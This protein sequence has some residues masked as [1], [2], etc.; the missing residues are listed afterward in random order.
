MTS[1]IHTIKRLPKAARLLWADVLSSALRA[2]V[3]NPDA[4]HLWLLLHALPKLCLRLPP[5]GGK[6]KA[7]S[8]ASKPFIVDLLKKAKE[9]DWSSLFEEAVASAR[10][11]VAKNGKKSQAPQQ[12][13]VKDWVTTLP[14]SQQA[15]IKDRVTSLIEEGLLSKA[16]AALDPSGMHILSPSVIATLEKKHPKGNYLPPALPPPDG[17]ERPVPLS[18]EVEA[19]LRALR[20]FHKSTAP[21][22]SR[23]R[24]S[25]LLDA[26]DIPT[27]DADG[28]VSK[29]LTKL[30][31]L[32]VAGDAPTSIAQWIAGAPLHPLMKKDGGVRPIAVGEV[33]RRLVSRACCAALNTSE[34]FLELGQVGV[35]VKGGAEAA[36]QAVRLAITPSAGV[37]SL[38]VLKV[39][40]EN[41]F[42][43]ADRLAIL[44]ELEFNFPQLVPWFRF[45]Y[46][47]PACLMCQGE[48]LPFGSSQGVQQGD[49]LGPFFFAL[50]LRPCCLKLKD[51]L[52]DSL[53]VWYL[54]DGTIVG[55]KEEV[56]K[57]WDVIHEEA[58]KVALRVNAGKC[59]L[60]ATADG[61]DLID[62]PSS[63]IRCSSQGFDLLGSPIGT[64]E[65]CNSYIK[66]KRVDKIAK[67]L[68]N[69]CL[70]NDPQLELTLLRSC[71]A[72][73][74]FAFALRSAPAPDIDD[75]AAA[76]DSLIDATWDER[77]GL[78][79]SP[80][81]KQQL[82]LPIR[83]GG[84][85][86]TTAADT[87]NAAFLGNIIATAP[88]VNVLLGRVVA[89]DEFSGAEQSL[90]ALKSQ[91]GSNDPLPQSVVGFPAYLSPPAGPPRKAAHPQHQFS[92]LVHKANQARVP[93]PHAANF[94]WRQLPGRRLVLGL[95]LSQSSS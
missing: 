70:I 60:F 11:S 52:K 41:A 93:T 37:D 53:S 28:R 94:I 46:G 56:L 23:L 63:I 81:Q 33:I 7:R 29:P 78:S 24:I 34:F 51:V 84:S 88:I 30:C 58:A 43:A 89:L 4:D 66:S 17:Q 44:K 83:L 25:H 31:N 47:N 42:N 20:G 48:V 38:V 57:A 61:V 36:V 85:G 69:L 12:S 62:F 21:G 16:C 40:F 35:G 74:K 6:R 9:H 75:A 15:F 2:V 90:Q 8:F 26:L 86:M 22:G 3:S 64:P 87:I 54:D 71:L 5:R 27:G 95:Q 14:V 18:F 65:W 10:G 76:F 32:L 80:V 55:R 82:T 72:M 73:P 39:D 77:F 79:L 45:C 19:I 68:H 59:E 67:A 13:F 49:P 91:I 92:D 1:P 50:A